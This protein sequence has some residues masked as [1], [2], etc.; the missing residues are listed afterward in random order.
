MELVEKVGV[1][2]QAFEMRLRGVEG[3]RFGEPIGI[4]VRQAPAVPRRP[5]DRDTHEPLQIALAL[6]A[7]PLA[8]PLEA[9][10]VG[11]QA[12]S[13][14]SRVPQAELVGGCHRV[15][16]TGWVPD[17]GT[18]TSAS[19]T[20]STARRAAGRTRA[21]SIATYLLCVY[22]RRRDCLADRG[23]LYSPP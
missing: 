20:R 8:G 10:G 17:G 21:P 23:A 5:L 11:R 19:H 1:G 12:G 22:A 16:G 15:H 18:P 13:R 9:L 2:L 3:H 4:D 7:D 14:L 6:R